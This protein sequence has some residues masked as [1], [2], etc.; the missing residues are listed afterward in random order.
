MPMRG[1]FDGSATT[2]VSI[3]LGSVAATEQ[4]WSAVEPEWLD[5]LAQHGAPPIHMKDMLSRRKDFK[6]WDDF[7]IYRLAHHLV[8]TLEA[9]RDHPEMWTAA[10]TVD[11]DSHGV[12]KRHRRLPSPERIC[13]FVLFPR[14]YDWYMGRSISTGES[15][16]VDVWFDQNEKF[17]GHVVSLWNNKKFRRRHPGWEIVRGIRE[18]S[19][20]GT[21]PLQIADMAAWSIN[22]LGS[23]SGDEWSKLALRIKAALRIYPLDVDKQRLLNDPYRE[24]I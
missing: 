18:A 10:C 4:Y 20:K 11:V 1:Y 19:Y 8:N 24:P 21:P 23:H 22:R 12:I 7:R 5:V 2:G 14:M 13:A 17:R 3:T 9:V 16:S 15:R 6:G